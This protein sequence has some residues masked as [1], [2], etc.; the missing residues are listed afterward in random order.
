MCARA[1]TCTRVCVYVERKTI[2]YNIGSFASEQ[3]TTVCMLLYILLGDPSTMYLRFN[4]TRV[5]YK[6]FVFVKRG[7]MVSSIVFARPTSLLMSIYIY[8]LSY[9]T[10]CVKYSKRYYVKIYME[11]IRKLLVALG[12]FFSFLI[13]E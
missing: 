7:H 6:F 11:K 8:L 13:F 3:F 4:C 1:C 10:L 5:S 12:Y 2:L 9:E